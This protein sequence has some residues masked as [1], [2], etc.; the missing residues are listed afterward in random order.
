MAPS[1][2]LREHPA[3]R[4]DYSQG[5]STRRVDSA[6]QPILIEDIPPPQEKS[7]RSAK[8]KQKGVPKSVRDGQGRYTISE[9]P[10]NARSSRSKV[11]KSAPPPKEAKPRPYRTECT[12]CA[13]SKTTKRSFKASSLVDTCE[14]FESI[15]DQCI[16]KQAKTRMAARQLAEA[17]LPCMFPQCEMVL[18][19][20][21]LK[22]VM[23]K[24]LFEE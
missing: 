15:C 9:G 8:T 2:R 7:K 23:S 20:S 1:T 11:A 13:T 3:R 18:D 19:H 6:R 10:T 5:M 21:A 14:H 4:V 24:A 16:Q 17:H 22:K 12:I